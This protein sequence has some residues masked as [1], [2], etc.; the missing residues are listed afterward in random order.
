MDASHAN[1]LAP[2]ALLLGAAATIGMFATL[3][4]QVAAA[5]ALI[6][7]ML[8]LP[9]RVQFDLPAVPPLTKWTITTLAVLIGCLWRCPQKIARARP[10]RGIDLIFI[11]VAVSAMGTI[12]TNR[13]PLTYGPVHLVGLEPYDAISLVAR[14][15]LGIGIPFFIGRALFRSA[16]DLRQLLTIFVTAGLIYTL[17]VLVEVRMS[18]QWHRWVY[19]FHQHSFQQ[20]VRYGGYRPMVFMIHGLAVAVFLTATTLVAAS[21]GRA[22]IRILGL[23]KAAIVVWLALVLALCKSTGAWVYGL[24]FL[25]VV[26]FLPA[27]F[28][29]RVAVLVCAVVVAY[30]AMR[31][32]LIF[33]TAALVE[34]AARFAPE[35]AHSIEFRFNQEDELF[36]KARE[37]PL[38]GWGYFGRN[39]VYNERGRDLSVTDGQWIILLGTRGVLGW[40]SAF[41]LLIVPVLAAGRAMRRVR[42][43]RDQILLAGLA[44][45]VSVYTIDLIPNGLFTEF[46]YFLAGALWSLRLTLARSRPRDAGSRSRLARGLDSKR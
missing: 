46:P 37:R 33:P 1:A 14:D 31:V 28:Q 43:R 26:A 42:D 34:T 10:G 16:R 32:T 17:F 2:L 12:L 41:A 19:G 22:R 15:L 6:G 36:A 3:R 24:L 20:A 27:R 18:P 30:P 5:V 13:D 25:P 45:A 4:P 11:V 35:R 8:F 23:P 39:H 38:F 40:L 9:E 44:M 21:L 29:M 7:A